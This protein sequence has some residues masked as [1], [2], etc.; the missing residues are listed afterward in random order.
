MPDCFLIAAE[1]SG[2]QTSSC[3]EPHCGCGFAALGSLRL[4]GESP[5][6]VRRWIEA[7]EQFGQHRYGEPTFLCRLEFDPKRQILLATGALRQAAHSMV[8]P[9]IIKEL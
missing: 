5:F 7:H 8:E 3:H 6:T 2:H 1:R 9:C 4:C